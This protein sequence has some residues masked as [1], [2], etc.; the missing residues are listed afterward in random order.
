MGSLFP[1]G[2]PVKISYACIIYPMHATH[3]HLIPLDFIILIMLSEAYK[4]QSSSLCSLLQPPATS[5]IL[6][7][8]ILNKL[9]LSFIKHIIMKMYE[10]VEVQ[11][12]ALF[13]H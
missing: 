3:P 6:G 5:S 9:P 2:F 8:N 10:G 11:H 7:P 4:L 12:H 13:R 1:S